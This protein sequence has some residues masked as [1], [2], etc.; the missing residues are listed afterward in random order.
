MVRALE[1]FELT[2]KPMSAWQ[3]QWEVRCPSSV[4][5]GNAATDHGPRPTDHVRWLD[6]PRDEL[7]ARINRRVE[8]MFA[9]G[10][11]EEVRGLRAQ[12]RPLSQEASQAL[13]YKEVF[14]YL[15]GRVSLDETVVQVQIRSRNFAKRQ[16]TWFRHLPDC[17]AV[18]KELTSALW[19]TE[20]KL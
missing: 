19:R 8:E 9:A 18:T 3:T 4:V 16:I 2:G 15:D 10:L 11:I 13:G 7:Y 6:L 12:G 17:R 14:A 20:I 5:R 1:V